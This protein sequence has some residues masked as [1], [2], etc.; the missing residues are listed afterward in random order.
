VL[1]VPDETVHRTKVADWL[2]LKAIS[3]PDGRV[4]FGTLISATALSEE[5]QPQDMADED[6]KEDALVLSAQAEITRRLKNIGND[7]PF[8]ID[9]TGRAMQFIAPVSKVGS[10]YLF[11]LFLSHAFDRTIMPKT[12]APRVTNKTRDLFQACA[13]VAAGGY[14]QGPSVS[15]GFP[16][17]DGEAFLKALHRVYKLFGDGKPRKKPRAAAA[18]K[19]KDNGIDI[20]AWRRSIDNLP[21]TLYL[22]GQVASGSDWEGK[23]VKPD[24]EHFHKYWFDVI[25]GSQPSDAMFMPFGLEPEDPEDGTA[26]D[27]VLTDYMQSVGHR[28]G[29]LFYRDR[30]AKYL[31]YGLQLAANGET[32]IERVG[33]VAKVATWVKKYTENLQA[34]V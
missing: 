12:L 18:K 29:T 19:I 5:E 7:Y 26:Y 32:E 1:A 34:A 30:V 27:D 14:V 10:V 13:T 24:Q 4:G 17:P 28:F 20:I 31:A 16:R 22:I 2:E 33:D 23:S 11:C 25:P 6:I 8:R 9:D 15:F 3:S 21:C